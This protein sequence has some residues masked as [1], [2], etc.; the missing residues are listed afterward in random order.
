MTSAT[1]PGRARAGLIRLGLVLLSAALMVLANPKPQLW[2]LA[3]V[4]LVPALFALRE[5]TGFAAFGWGWLLGLLCNIAG[6]SWA[7]TV[8]M[9]FGKLTFVSAALVLVAVSA[10]QGLVFALW[11]WA[12][13]TLTT[14]T[15]LPLLFSAA[16]AMVA[17]EL[18]I[19]FLMPWTLALLVTPCW[20]A[21]QVA[22]LCGSWAVTFLLVL[23]NAAVFVILD[24]RLA[25][26]ALP[27][28]VLAAAG[29]LIVLA[30]G[31][32][33]IRGAQVTRATARA[34][35]LRVGLVQPNFGITTRGV[36]SAQWPQM[37]DVLRRESTLAE[38]K[39][40]QLVI[41]PE[42][43]WP[44]PVDRSLGA[45]Y[46]AGHPWQ[47]RRGL[48]VPLLA[49]VLTADFSSEQQ[50][51]HNSAWLLGQDGRGLGRYDK[52]FLMPFGEYVPLAARYPDWRAS[53][54]ARMT[55]ADEL[56][57]GREP[58]VLT[59][60][61]ARLGPMIC[62][63]D[64]LA[65]YVWRVARLQPNLL[66]TLS[67]VAWFGDSAEP[68]QQLLLAQLRAVE[69]RRE[70]LRAT[71]TGVSAHVDALGRV[72]ARTVVTDPPPTRFGVAPE[73]LVADAALLD[74][75]RTLYG[76]IGDLFAWLCAAVVL[77]G[78]ALALL[79]RP[80]RLARAPE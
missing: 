52:N 75:G 44:L 32:G 51:M 68:Y 19:P 74:T 28:R 42:S 4:A 35:K 38:A 39:G 7:T 64:I 16:A 45:D 61:P 3:L 20:P 1:A 21:I 41:W 48:T 50:P 12:T 80:A 71:N 22:E 34:P 47:L 5:R 18:A 69:H 59:V 14:R 46:P 72:R 40:A 76:R 36:R 43:A 11:A 17:A 37:V 33:L 30:L 10:Y 2:P 70:F 24:A 57:R 63:E 55:E 27:R 23:F 67:N 58:A 31:F 60:G 54:R 15:R 79:G 73:L 62:Y 65:G 13:Q 53:V 56:M 49:G 29:G 25:G 66:V 8:L 26:R 6:Q 78:L 77:L 9:R